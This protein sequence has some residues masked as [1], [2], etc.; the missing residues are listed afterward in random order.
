MFTDG[1][2][3]YVKIA[4]SRKRNGFSFVSSAH[5]MKHCQRGRH[6]RCFGSAFM[7]R[8]RIHKSARIT[9]SSKDAASVSEAAG[10]AFA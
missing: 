2:H 10:R 7:P 3:V 9:N 1:G 6:S 5:V 4:S 8:Q